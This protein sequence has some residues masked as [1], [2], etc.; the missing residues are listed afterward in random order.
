[1]VPPSI[2]KGIQDQVLGKKR[3]REVPFIAPVIVSAADY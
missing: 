3:F 2:T 1:M